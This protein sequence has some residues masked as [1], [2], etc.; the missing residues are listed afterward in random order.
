ML[1]ELLGKH[2]SAWSIGYNGDDNSTKLKEKSFADWLK[3]AKLRH[4]EFN[5]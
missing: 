2:P 4:Q 1:L 3:W 5:A